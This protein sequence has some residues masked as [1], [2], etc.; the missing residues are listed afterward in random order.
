MTQLAS[1]DSITPATYP[2]DCAIAFALAV[3][4]SKPAEL[5]INRTDWAEKLFLAQCDKLSDEVTRIH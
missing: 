1:D 3:V 2:P 4:K 5:T